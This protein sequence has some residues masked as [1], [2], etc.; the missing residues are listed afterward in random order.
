MV[1]ALAFS[2]VVQA[3]DLGVDISHFQNE[4]GIPQSNWNQL[5]AEGRTFAYIKATEGLTGPDDATMATNVSRA[6]SAGI[7]NGV[8]HFAHSENRPTTAGAVL[9]ADHLLSFAGAAI[10]PGHL[11]PVIDVEGNNQNL[12]TAGLTD[13]VIAFIN[14]IVEQR[15]PAAEPIIYTTSFFTTSQFDSRIADYD[16]WIRSN[17][18]DPQTGNPTNLGVFPDWLLWQYNVASAGGISP[19]DLDVVHSEVAP[20]SSLLIPEPSALAFILLAVFPHRRR[21]CRKRWACFANI[22]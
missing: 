2:S 12:T 5:A 4:S 19:I 6:T 18:A 17:F 1:L 9:E 10:G 14:R 3:R 7:L 20:L 11:R 15:G 13:W 21:G 8:Y 16:L 22:A